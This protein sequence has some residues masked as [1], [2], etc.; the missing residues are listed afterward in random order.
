MTPDRTIESLYEELVKEGIIVRCP[1]IR[2]S[3]FEGEYSY[4]GTTL[5]QANIE[6]MP[7]LSDVRRLV[8]EFGILPLGSQA[9]HEQ[10]PLTKSILLAGPR[11]T[12]KKMLVQAVC[13]E[14]GANMFD[15]TAANIAGKYPGKDGLKMLIHLVFKVGRE[16]Q[17]SVI[18]IGDC[19]RM[20]KKKIPKTDPTDPKR[21]KKE[22][23]KA[24]KGVKS[25][26]RLLLVG[27]SRCPFD[28][29]M[30]PLC[31]LYQR[32]ILIPRPDYAS[33]HLLWRRL[34]LKNNGVITNTL[35]VSSLSK[36]TD[37]YTP[38]HMLTAITQVLTERRIQTLSKKPL[39]SVE[40][41]APLARID[42]IYKE[43]EEAFKGWYAKTP[44][45]KKRAKAAQADDD[46]GGGGK[47]GKGGK[48]K[49]GKKK[50]GKKKKK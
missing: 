19:E 36:V 43:E 25:D 6:P 37:G 29:E 17:P 9:V 20:F 24:M 12:G 22:L 5:R 50:G 27:T 45:G 14:V 48:G 46:D 4:L 7:S 40:F 8:T 44:L 16:L 38:G 34:I 41:I 23:P 2:L 15:L 13:N 28:G 26:D 11:G 10:A 1:Q 42:P 18:Y 3:E 32:I 35:D 47:G 39:Q 21:L 49:K 31:S 33:R 30:K